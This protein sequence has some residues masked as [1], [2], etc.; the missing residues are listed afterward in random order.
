MYT[1]DLNSAM[2]FET[3]RRK[4]EMAE[5]RECCRVRQLLQ[6]RP[7]KRRGA[8]PVFLINLFMLALALFHRH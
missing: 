3:E 1:Q 2:M 6:D 7:V 4:D 8:L 5:A